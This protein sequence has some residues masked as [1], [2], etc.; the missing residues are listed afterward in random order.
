[1]P[2]IKL[3]NEMK[4]KILF[5]IEKSYITRVSG[6]LATWK[7]K[8]EKPIIETSQLTGYS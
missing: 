6:N 1:M 8:T 3:L 7:Q 2:V 5:L 4:R